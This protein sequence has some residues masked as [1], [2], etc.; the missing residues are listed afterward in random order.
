MMMKKFLLCTVILTGLSL[1]ACVKKEAP[2]EEAGCWSAF[3][4]VSNILGIVSLCIFWIPFIGVYAFL[5]GVP[6]IVFGILGKHSNKENVKERASS[7]LLKSILGTVFGILGFIFLMMILS[8]A[9][10]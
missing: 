5:P 9:A 4:K 6:G 3:S 1:T 2:K 8:S 7:G 10:K